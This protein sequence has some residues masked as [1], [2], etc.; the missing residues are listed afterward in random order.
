MF[1]ARFQ[2]E[3]KQILK[4]V[5][6][7]DNIFFVNNSLHLILGD[8]AKGCASL[9]GTISPGKQV[10]LLKGNLWFLKCQWDPGVW[11]NTKFYC[12]FLPSCLWLFCLA[13]STLSLTSSTWT[14]R[15]CLMRMLNSN[16]GKCVWHK[17]QTQLANSRMAEK[18]LSLSPFHH[19]STSPPTEPL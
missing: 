14:S 8:G 11:P 13:L 12:H 2:Q 16:R 9:G 18:P 1:W 5:S 15:A 4:T 3:V 10:F 7:K 19:P 17:G 6:G